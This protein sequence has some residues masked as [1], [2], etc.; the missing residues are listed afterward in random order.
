MKIGL[1]LYFRNLN[2][3]FNLPIDKVLAL[4]VPVSLSNMQA[5]PLNAVAIHHRSFISVSVKK[6]LG[7]ILGRQQH[8]HAAD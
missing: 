7:F 2:T 8:V 5:K 1:Q 6:R 3:M 4:T